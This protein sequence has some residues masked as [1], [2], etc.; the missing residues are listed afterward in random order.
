MLKKVC[1]SLIVIIMF[2][3]SVMPAFASSRNVITDAAT[4]N[5][6]QFLV[7]ITK[8]EKDEF[9]F[10]KSYVVCG[11]TKNEN[12]RV[13]LLRFNKDTNKYEPFANVD[14]ETFWR[15]GASGIFMKEVVLQDGPN[16][17]RIVAYKESDEGNLK[18]GT[19]LQVNNF[20][21]TVLK[22]SLKDKINNVFLRIG[23][24]VDSILKK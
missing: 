2:L 4:E 6:E 23:D 22:E 10:K 3:V 24:M 21:I 8:P 17:I 19:T 13:E 18:A 12:I 11:N 16:Q 14:G 15:I 5:T 9:T 1:L 20:T 7:T